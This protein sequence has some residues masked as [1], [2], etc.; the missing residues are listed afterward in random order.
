LWVGRLQPWKGVDVALRALAEVPRAQ[1]VIAG[2]GQERQALEAMSGELGLSQRVHFLGEVPRAQL[3]RVYSAADLLLATS[4]ASETFGIGPV[5]AQA[6]GLPV[7]ASRFG[8]F[9]EVIDEGRTGV[10]VPP[11][12]SGALAAA[13]N[14]LLSQPAR[15]QAMAAAGPGWAARFS[16]QA[17]TDRVEQAYQQ[18]QAQGT[19]VRAR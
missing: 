14:D 1:L 7:V 5:E 4:Y 13:I 3:P 8:G 2:A 9:P 19:P 18:A 17:V 16:W 15:R 12:D 10:L 6:C 11:R